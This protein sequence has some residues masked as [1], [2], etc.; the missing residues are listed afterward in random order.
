MQSIKSKNKFEMLAKLTKG[1]FRY[2]L[3]KAPVKNEL[4]QNKSSV[5]A[6]IKE[7][8]ENEKRQHE[9]SHTSSY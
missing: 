8:K 1:R 7:E 2:L 4:R 3:G 5:E 6:L 9:K